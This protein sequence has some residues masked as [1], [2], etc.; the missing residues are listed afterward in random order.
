MTSAVQNTSAARTLG[1]VMYSTAQS[2]EER[3]R[4]QHEAKNTE[5]LRR[6]LTAALVAEITTRHKLQRL[7]PATAN[8][9]AMQDEDLFVSS[10]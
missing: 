9:D 8:G 10:T 3:H 4:T 1:Q 2:P 6:K 7:N 5:P